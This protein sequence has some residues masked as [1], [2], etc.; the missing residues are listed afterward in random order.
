L[1]RGLEALSPVAVL[2]RGYSVARDDT[3]RAVRAA[4]QL[5]PGAR[6]SIEFA[7]GRAQAT[8]DSVEPGE[9]RPEQ[10]ERP[11]ANPA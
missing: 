10:P 5:A 9:A 1:A 7:R 4:E 2:A 3:G 11:G 8:V 6:L